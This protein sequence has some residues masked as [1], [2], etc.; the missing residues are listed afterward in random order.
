MR[1]IS[2]L[3]VA[4][5]GLCSLLLTS[6]CTPAEET[7]AREAARIAM[8]DPERRSAAG[9]LLGS[10]SPSDEVAASRPEP[11]E[12]SDVLPGPEP[13]P[14]PVD[15]RTPAPTVPPPTP[16][17]TP[18]PTA[19]TTPSPTPLPTPSPT[20]SPT[21]APGPMSSP[22]STPT[23]ISPEVSPSPAG[24]TGPDRAGLLWAGDAETGD[25]SQFVD[26]PWNN[27]GGTKPRV[28]TDP[29]RGGTFAVELG[30]TGATD[31]SDGICCGS[32]NELLPK[33]RD[34][35]EGDDLYFGFST[36]LEPGF[37]TSGGWQVITQFKQNFDGSPPLSLNVEDGQYKFEGGYGYPGGSRLFIKTLAP[38]TTGQ[39]VDWVIHVSFSSN[40]ANGYVEVWKDDTLALARFAPSGGTLYPASD[41]QLGG[42]VKTG[43]YR[44]PGITAPGTMYLDEWRIG[45]SREAVTP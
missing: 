40:P 31:S 35:R 11:Q 32:R 39:W 24:G 2:A 37:P 33:F 21:P 6:A 10:V 29:V 38:A 22:G 23:P 13:E 17:Q 5:G 15:M 19:S 43:P 9:G 16:T 30:L 14:T 18:S 41:D 44:D 12:S 1:R 28:V 45:T 42:Y 8:S 3:A 7:Q 34:L 27:V 25:L 20:P 4:V 26:G 36:F